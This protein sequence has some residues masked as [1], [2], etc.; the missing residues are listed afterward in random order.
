M[1]DPLPMWVTR[2]VLSTFRTLPL[3]PQ[4]QIVLLSRSKRRSGPIPNSRTGSRQDCRSSLV[5]QEDLFSA[6]PFVADWTKRLVNLTRIVL[7][8]SQPLSD[9][10]GAHRKMGFID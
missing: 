3:C 5:V 10:S 4:F 8:S 2:D 9:Q 7:L 6:T 1:R